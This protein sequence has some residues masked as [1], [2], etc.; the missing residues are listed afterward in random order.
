[1]DDVISRAD[2]NNTGMVE[3][4]EYEAIAEEIIKSIIAKNEST[5]RIKHSE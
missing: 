5:N 2:S 4:K 1:L 3:Y